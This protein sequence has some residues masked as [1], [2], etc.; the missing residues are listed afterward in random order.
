MPQ[1][2][3]GFLQRRV[4]LFELRFGRRGGLVLALGSLGAAC[5]G[6]SQ[7]PWPD[8]QAGL[9]PMASR[10]SVSATLPAD[11]RIQPPGPDVPP[12][13]RPFSG[14]WTGWADRGA[15][16]SVA[17]AVES[18]TASGG[19]I[20]YAYASPRVRPFTT[21]ATARLV[22]GN[23]LEADL[24]PSGAVIN[25]RIRGDGNMDFMWR[26]ARG[27]QSWVTGLLTRGAQP[28]AS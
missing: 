12:G 2:E 26:S 7:T 16:A 18:L 28:T 9:G 13:L 11:V 23:E 1:S 6:M 3:N 24:P 25:L 5:G 17:I 10:S 20:A 8:F 21:R 14:I 27:S 15:A 4:D 19:S 22:P